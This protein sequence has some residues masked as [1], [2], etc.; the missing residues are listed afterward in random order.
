MKWTIPFKVALNFN[1]EHEEDKITTIRHVQFQLVTIP[2]AEFVWK[3][4]G[5]QNAGVSSK[6]SSR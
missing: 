2:P 1:R 6:F 3:S 5:H 4:A